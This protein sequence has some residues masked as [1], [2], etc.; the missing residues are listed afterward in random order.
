MTLK[1]KLEEKFFRILSAI[2][3]LLII[4]VLGHIIFSILEKGFSSLS[5]QIVSQE[6][7]G[8]FYFGKE[9]GILNAIAGSFYLAV[10][11]TVLAFIVSLPVALFMNTYLWTLISDQ[12]AL[13]TR[14]NITYKYLLVNTYLL[15]TYFRLNT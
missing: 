8:G 6:P 11:A 5:W 4:F 3:T 14:I 7:K 13:T 12:I 2:T 15:D 9:G 1:R 10:C